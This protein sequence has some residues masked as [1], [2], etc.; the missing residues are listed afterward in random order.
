[1]EGGF[2]LGIFEALRKRPEIIRSIARNLLQAHFPESLHSA[3][4]TAVAIDLDATTRNRL[5]DARFRDEV[6]AAWG[7]K[8]GFCGYDLKLDNSD[9]GLEAAH[10][11]WVQAGGPD[12]LS[13]G[14]S[15]CALHHQALD[16]G[17][18]GIDETLRIIVSSRLHGNRSLDEL[19]L[20]LRGRLLTLPSFLGG[21]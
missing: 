3:I 4:S 18:I 1:M 7:H 11:Q 16:R 12:T 2:P 6:I 10:I 14:I 17:A 21:S 19:F 5:R 8:C 13:N 15:C 20:G 9:L